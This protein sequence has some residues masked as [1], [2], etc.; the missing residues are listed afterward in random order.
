MSHLAMTDGADAPGQGRREHLSR[1]LQF[2]AAGHSAA[3]AAADG[4]HSSAAG[5]TRN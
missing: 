1:A 4:E 3:G 5:L 2:N